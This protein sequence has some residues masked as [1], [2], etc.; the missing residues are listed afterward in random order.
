VKKTAS[1]IRTGGEMLGKV[2]TNGKKKSRVCRNPQE[3][4][5]IRGKKAAVVKKNRLKEKKREEKTDPS[6]I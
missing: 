4:Q 6:A 1:E 3:C 2:H 5:R